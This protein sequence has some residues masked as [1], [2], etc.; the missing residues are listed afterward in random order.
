MKQNEEHWDLVIVPKTPWLDLKLKELWKYRDLLWLW[1]RRTYVG[2]YKQTIMGPLWHFITP[3]FGTVTY[4]L[5]FGKIANLPTDGVPMFLFYNLGITAWNFFSGCFSSSSSAFTANAGIFGK[6]YFPRLIMPLASIISSL[7]KLG[8]Q[9]SLFILVY[10]Y[11]IFSKGFH[12]H[13]GTGLLLIPVSLLLYAGIG[14]GFGI[15]VSSITTKYRD[16]N[17]F[18]GFIM[19]LLMYATPVIYS[20]TTVNAR[21]KPYLA[22]NP[23]VAPT[24]AFKYAFFGVGE[25]SL[26][27]LMYSFAWM[28]VLMLGGIILFNRTEKNF[29]DNV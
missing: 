27:S 18:V 5:V 14:F 19:Q 21:L 22:F 4:M 10:F 6:V 24:E 20:F 29:M 9:M 2:T 17:I 3:I 28:I 12:P 8:I 26:S 13:V 7:I 23:L 16:I 11:F 15:M 25:F 1:V